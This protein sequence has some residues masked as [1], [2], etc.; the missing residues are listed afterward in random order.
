MTHVS[1]VIN[2]N[3]ICA[4]ERVDLALNALVASAGERTIV[5][6]L[7]YDPFYSQLDIYIS[8]EQSDSRL[9]IIY[10]AATDFNRN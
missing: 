4:G 6:R 7:S 1:Y 3:F 8:Y 10:S 2:L 9:N 5:K